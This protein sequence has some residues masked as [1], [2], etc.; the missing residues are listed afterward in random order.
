VSTTAELHHK[1]MGLVDG[2]LIAKREGDEKK[3]LRLLK[4]ALKFEKDAADQVADTYDFEP[5]RSVLHRSAA[6]IAL[7]CG[8]LSVA[9]KLV[10]R[11]ILGNPP[12]E[13]AEELRD[14]SEQVNFQRHLAL[15]GIKLES[16]EFQMSIAGGDVGYGVAPTNAFVDRVLTTEKLLYRTAE[17]KAGRPYR[18]RGPAPRPFRGE[19]ELY[20][21]VP[22][23][24]SLAV[25]FRMGHKEQLALP[26]F[27]YS[28]DVVDELFDCLHAF[29]KLDE[30]TLK[31]RISNQA[32]FLNFVGLA[33]NL[34]PD[35]ESVKLVGF[36][37]SRPAGNV[38][39]ALT[40]RQGDVPSNLL[41]RM[42][43]E[44]SKQLRIRGRLS[45]A[46]ALG[47]KHQIRLAGNKEV[48][49]VPEGMM[50]DIVRPMWGAEVSV[51]AER[52]GKKL[53]LLDIK[54]EN[55]K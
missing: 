10:C 4:N 17:R 24:A 15:R 6:S 41:G 8:E 21:S 45:F 23:A 11:A 42:P 26:G 35:G 47:H 2:A 51:T 43:Q 25:S 33:R 16:N 49:H 5:T 19:L 1:A 18:E 52:R 36:T 37:S 48:I 50:D 40:V 12:D 53:I 54:A 20:M 7:D 46:D 29:N 28:A 13:I 30:K 9:E 34:A 32:Y 39:V 22:R 14:L 3:Y 31:E 55:S 44:P 27:S 38:E